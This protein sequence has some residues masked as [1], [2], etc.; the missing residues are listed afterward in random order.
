LKF[1]RVRRFAG[2]AL[3]LSLLSAHAS[4]A[5]SSARSADLRHRF[6]A[7]VGTSL[8]GDSFSGTATVANA[9]LAVGSACLTAGTTTTPT[10]SVPACGS[11]AT[12]DPAGAGALALTPSS[13]FA[14]GMV[15]SRTAIP[16]ANGVV[17][18]FDDA[19]FNG[20]SSGTPGA[21]GMSS[22][23][24][25]A[26]QALPTSAG[27]Y[28]GALGYA[29]APGIAN[30][31]LGIGYD[32]YG[33]FSNAAS[34]MSGGPGVIP[35]SIAVRGAA[36]SG[37]QYLG[38]YENAQ[39]AA[40]GLPFALDSFSAT[41]R[42]PL[43]PTIREQLTASGTL[44]VA[45][46][47]HDGNGYFTYFSR[48]V[49]GVNGEPAVP[50]NV[51]VGFAGSTGGNFERHQIA[52]VSITTIGGPVIGDAFSEQATPAGAFGV[53]GGACLT[54]G[55]SATAATSIPACG[56]NAPVD[57]SGEGALQL[58]AAAT[59]QTGMVVDKTAFSTAAGVHVTFTDDA[60]NGAQAGA[61]G[62]AL[63]FTDASAALP[64]VPGATGGSLG[65]GNS[66]AAGLANAY[67]GVGFDEYGNFSSTIGGSGGPGRIAETIAVRGSAATSYAYIG[68]YKNTAGQAAS[69]P[70]NLDQPSQT[71][72]SA[73]APTIDVVLSAAG[74]LTVSID[75]HDGNGS[76]PYYSGAVA[77]VAGEPAVPANVYVGLTAATGGLSQRHQVTGFSVSAALS[78]VPR[79]AFAPTAISNLQAWYDATNTASIT[80]T[81]T[82]VTAWSDASGH[83]NTL[84]QATASLEPA[85]TATGID[86]LGSLTFNGAPYMVGSNASFSTSLFNESTVFVVSNQSSATQTSSV[87]WSGSYLA[88]PRW[89][90]RL[91]EGGVSHFDL[92]N[93]EA[94]RLT[95]SDVP[96]GPALWTAIGS[97]AN[98]VQ[99]LR[100]DG[101]ILSSSTGPGATV[102]G[103]YPLV[104][105]AT[106]GSG[107]VTDQYSGQLGELVVYNRLLT[108]AETAS[109]EGYL[110][111]KWGLQNR[112]P[113]NHPYRT[114]CPQGGTSVSQPF[115]APASGELAD[116]TQLLSQNGQLVF[117]V[118]ATQNSNGNPQL[119]YNGST[120]P[121]TLR[122]LPGDT[123]IVN[124]TNNL[125][126]PAAG[127]TILNDTNLHFHGLHVSP[128]APG[129]DSIDLLAMP[130]QSLH[131]QVVIP[132]NHPTGLYWYHSHAH[133]EAE[134]QNLSG[135][136]GAL[137]VDGISQYVPAVTS[138]LERIL[139]VRDV[140]PSGQA[141]PDAD[142]KQIDAMYWA[143]HHASKTTRSSAGMQRMAGMPGMAGMGS[144]MSMNVAV[145]GSSNASTRN[146]Y[147]VVN[148]HF[149]RFVRPLVASTH[150]TGS[151]TAVKNWTVNGQSM[152]SIGIRPGVQQ[153][154]RLVNAGSDTYL[155]VAVDNTQM[156]IVALDGV[157]LASVGNAPLMVSHYVVP[158]SSRIEF[159]V[160][161]PAAGAT[162][163]LRTNCFDAGSAGPAMPA[164]TLA[165]LSATSSLS[166]N[167]RRKD[168]ISKIRALRPAIHSVAYFHRFIASG[169]VVRS[170]TLTYSDQNTINGL[171]YDP[172][173]AAQ[174]YAQAGTMEQWS[175]VNNSSQV[176]TFHI[177]QVH[178]LVDQIVGGTAIEQSNIGQVLDNINVPSATA[179]GP[180]TVTLT[181]DFTDPSIVGTFLLHCH[182][183]SHEDAGMM[184]KITIGT[185]PPLTTSSP[186]GVTFASATSASQ[187]VTVSGG[188]A[189]YSV[190]GCTGVA[191]ASVSGSTVTIKPAAAGSCILTVADTSGLTANVSV[192][193]T[194]AAAAITVAPN[195]LAYA[196]PTAAAQ[197]AAIS[198][199]KP[200]YAV[201]GCT[202]V[203][204]ASISGSTL[205]VTPS[206]AGSCTLAVTDSASN[207]QSVSV[208][209]N[210][211]VSGAA[212]DNVTFHQNAARQ[213]WYQAET[214]L[215][216]ATVASSSFGLLGTLSAPSGMPAF[217]KVYA[218]PLYASAE[219]IGGT[220]HNLVIVS[221]A[222]DLVYAFDDQTDAVVWA[223]NFTNPSAGITQQL[224]SDTGCGDV[225]P[226]IGII[227]TPVIDRARDTMYVVVATKENG[228]FHLR[229]HAISLQNGTDSVAPVEVSASTTLA[230]GGVATTNPE[231]NFSRTALLEAN[232]T[233]YVGLGSH[234]DYIAGSTHGWIMGFS[235][236]NLAPAGSAIN[237]TNA[238]PGNGY[239]LGA[240]WMS[241]FGPAADAQGNIYYVTGN[242]P[243]NG[244]TDFGMSLMKVPGTL[245]VGNGSYFTPITEATESNADKDFGSGGVMLPPDGVTSAFPHIAIAS[246][247]DGTR[248]VLNRDNL[249]GQQTGD[250]GALYNSANNGG[251]WG[252]PAYFQDASGTSYV[253]YGTGNPLTISSINAS[254]GLSPFATAN[255]GCLECRNA[256]SQPIVSSNGTTAGSTVVWALKT[257]GSSGGTITL[258]AFDARTLA[259]L[260][261]GAAGTWTV[262]SGASYIGGALISPVV[263]N[264]RVYVPTDGSVA[265]FGLK[266]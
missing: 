31:Y 189:P 160:T 239:F 141:L 216:S 178:F 171:S 100:K 253:V 26:S 146:P 187:T 257:P 135:M 194:A 220:T 47:R 156:Q 94:G 5:A 233:I 92:N 191:T 225:N 84:S 25:D 98:G 136:S 85:Y 117:N 21:D 16:T 192:T 179:N 240:I 209:V 119:T 195:S 145:R 37:Y 256:G 207:S 243:W 153:F 200:P 60:F 67:L 102:T 14:V 132:A 33:N 114:T 4:D 265:V 203:A 147:V 45:I 9:W 166:D 101:K 54:A 82:S 8:A 258:Y 20:G 241:G 227:S 129:D 42:P 170:Q 183:L 81:G 48:P 169:A 247:K 63:F 219:S 201:Q 108:A 159:I 173:G 214:H 105:G 188:V 204:T 62:L 263:A 17:I 259:T 125:P 83:R 19:T 244:T 208:T 44:T 238:D 142:R 122:L 41:V 3:S 199:G 110:A 38:G 143:M 43:P 72:R 24:T 97:V 23:L 118:A 27:G 93:K 158:P 177:H 112:L 7:S 137:I 113:A 215:T 56:A 36:S 74:A 226:D 196:S 139:I 39:G 193:V 15:V 218:Q 249:G 152:P 252:G 144:H 235:A 260:Y 184:S 131:Y 57:P 22:F 2:V 58:T 109:V 202:S 237:I 230:T 140:E 13:E 223:R 172:G 111:C 89:S 150:C 161:G 133:G 149:R 55:T 71:V 228:V 198:G 61:D 217:G 18:T 229:L 205:T 266:P 232:N 104:L 234:C 126:V 79:P 59:Y 29:G 28:G 190:N 151:E 254:A 206:A 181:M 155:D 115:P 51:Y 186:N 248:Y 261:T 163:Y 242:G 246:G 80:K 90:L 30:A 121:P 175:I 157:P 165:V 213:G 69:L 35:D 65:Y 231:N 50:K 251:I 40:T 96:N 120:V 162:D 221:T 32:T 49:A 224:W 167:L 138:M 134:R 212:V 182:I 70:F 103:N 264:G 245:N 88:D 210:A 10:T 77:G 106:A 52:N 12:Q 250:A 154:W 176:H 6:D 46:D 174:F 73:N 107:N 211:P 75:R 99:Q 130:G 185:A 128:N 66:G 87:A 34:G 1:L 91:S 11:A 148:T 255:P 124:L 262:G 64:T 222:T 127:S 168:R 53:A 236:S 78:T 76:L 68:G 180:G 116:P 86:N 164:A 95:S 197:T 123:L